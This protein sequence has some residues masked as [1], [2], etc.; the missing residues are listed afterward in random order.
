MRRKSEVARVSSMRQCRDE[1]PLRSC[2]NQ[3][4]NTDQPERIFSR[5]LALQNQMSQGQTTSTLYLF[6]CST[7]KLYSQEMLY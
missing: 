1:T 5:K 3:D 2:P 6:P 7:R 4:M